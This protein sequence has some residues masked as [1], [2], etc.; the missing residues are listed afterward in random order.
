M[1]INMIKQNSED[2]TRKNIILIEVIKYI[3]GCTIQRII[4]IT[5]VA[6]AEGIFMCF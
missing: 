5:N 1:K 2:D 6:M 3:S 4:M